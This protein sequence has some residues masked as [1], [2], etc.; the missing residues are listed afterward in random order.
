MAKLANSDMALIRKLRGVGVLCELDSGKIMSSCGTIFVG[1]PDADQFLDIYEHHCAMCDGEI[2][3]HPLC[4]NGGALLLSK[5][6]PIPFARADG[7]ALL[8][9]VS[10]AAALKGISSIAL[11]TH[12]PCGV[13]GKYKLDALEVTR[14]LLEAKMRLKNQRRFHGFKLHCFMHVDFSEERGCK[15]TYFVNKSAALDYLRDNDRPVR[16]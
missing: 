1:C 10:E 14:L 15:R 3:H 12:A 16:D 11:Y 13:A 9:H 6:S 8:R 2:R 5:H 7:D 4:L